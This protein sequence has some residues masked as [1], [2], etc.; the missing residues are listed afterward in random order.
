LDT[1]PALDY[2]ADAHLGE[3]DRARLAGVQQVGEDDRLAR[4]RAPL[5]AH[6]Q[7]FQVGLFLP[8]PDVVLERE[9]REP[10]V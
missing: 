1:F 7:P 3:D 4:E 8:E 6:G 9:E 10:G 5:R 2:D